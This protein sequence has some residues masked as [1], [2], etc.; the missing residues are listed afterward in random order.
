MREGLIIH[1]LTVGYGKRVVLNDL[2]VAFPLG[3][4]AVMAP[5][6]YGKTTLLDAICG[7]V[8]IQSGAVSFSGHDVGRSPGAIHPGR[9]YQDYR[10]VPFLNAAEN[11]RLVADLSSRRLSDLDLT[12]LIDVVGLP[13]AVLT[14][15]PDQLSGGEQQRVAIARALVMETPVLLA[16]EPTGALDADSTLLIARLLATIGQG[17][18]VVVTATHDPLVA[19]QMDHLLRLDEEAI[20]N[21][22]P[23]CATSG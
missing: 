23:S 20:P 6:G 15:F 10:L 2:S 12:G 22:M 21:R 13:H 17:G 4:T 14:A 1:G 5:S 7:D 8:D 18:R 16:D 19:E 3:S 11:L 9:I